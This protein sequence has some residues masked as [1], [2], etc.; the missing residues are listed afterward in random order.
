M[1]DRPTFYTTQDIGPSACAY[2]I[3]NRG[4][5]MSSLEGLGYTLV[6]SWACPESRCSVLFR[7]SLK[8]RNYAGMYFRLAERGTPVAA[9]RWRGAASP[10]RASSTRR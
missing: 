10:G 2:R 5:L 4:E 3:G 9:D 6:D 1:T 7:P 8:V